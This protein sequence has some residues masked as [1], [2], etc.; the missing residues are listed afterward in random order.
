MLLSTP[1]P[2]RHHSDTRFEGRKRE[3]VTRSD[4]DGA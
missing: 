1:D 4:Q 3:L 2:A